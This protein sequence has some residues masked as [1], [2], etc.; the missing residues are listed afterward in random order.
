MRDVLARWLGALFGAALALAVILV[1]GP[2][3]IRRHVR[4]HG[5]PRCRRCGLP[6]P[7]DEPC[8]GTG[9]RIYDLPRVDYIND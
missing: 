7:C 8:T 2:G 9:G 3:Y 1:F 4:P 6:H 5:P